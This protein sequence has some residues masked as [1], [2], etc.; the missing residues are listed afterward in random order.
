MASEPRMEEVSV[1]KVIQCVMVI[2]DSEDYSR[3]MVVK[4]RKNNHLPDDLPDQ[5][6]LK[7]IWSVEAKLNRLRK[8]ILSEITNFIL[9][10]VTIV[11][12]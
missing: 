3:T 1:E 9:Q 10:Y 2:L 5:L 4:F 8:T 7:Y 12:K 6:R 11:K